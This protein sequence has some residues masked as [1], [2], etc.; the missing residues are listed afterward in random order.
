[1]NELLISL[2]QTIFNLL[3]FV[4]L[5]VTTIYLLTKNKRFADFLVSEKPKIKYQIIA[6][7]LFGIIIILASK[8]AI[9]IMGA[10]VNI[11]TC[12]AIFSGIIAGPAAG[13][14][15]GLIGGIYRM[16]LGGW[17]ALPCGV[18]TIS[19]GL[20]GAYLYK[21]KGYKI[22]NITFR[23]IWIITII[24]GVW[25]FI[26]VDIFVPLL[27]EKPILEAL[28]IANTNLLLPMALLNMLG[29]AILLL[30]CKDGKE[31]KASIKIKE[32]AIRADVKTKK[33]LKINNK[34][35]QNKIKEKTKELQ[36]VNVIL[37]KNVR[38]RTKELEKAKKDLNKKVEERTGDLKNSKN[39][40]E[41]AKKELEQK[42]KE[43]EQTLDD[44]YT[45]RL[46]MQK[47]LEKGQIK[48][49]NQEIKK[50]LDK[51]RNKIKR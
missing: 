13:I 21:Y 7:I 22:K 42:N 9:I 2:G 15:V 12:I 40:L 23:Q 24:A 33:L 41:K 1:M 28:S 45:M 14:A 39:E 10:R 32:D 25:E 47:E 3:V 38:E 50:R 49:E 20:I 8:Y 4:S 44:F 43:L 6:V 37:E 31:L 26:H 11:R 51:L 48:K 16:S 18:A 5:S 27:G 30:V 46:T 36:N 35:L 19:A 17:T 29:I 34:Q